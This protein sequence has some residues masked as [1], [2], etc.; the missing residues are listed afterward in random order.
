MYFVEY[1]YIFGV[2]IQHSDV[3][4]NTIPYVL[5]SCATRSTFKMDLWWMQETGDL[6]RGIVLIR[7]HPL[8]EK[9]LVDLAPHLLDSVIEQPD[10]LPILS[11]NSFDCCKFD[12]TYGEMLVKT[13]FM[14]HY[15]FAL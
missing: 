9:V 2:A 10:I 12:H 1:K 5:A 8:Y 7:E 13:Q 6:Q 3:L 11:R 4:S 15:L 14:W